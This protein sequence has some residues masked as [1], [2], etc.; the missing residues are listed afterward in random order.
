MHSGLF[1]FKNQSPIMENTPI[2][3]DEHPAD[4]EAEFLPAYRLNKYLA[5]CGIGS[6]RNC[7]QLITSGKVIVNGATCTNPA[8]Q[9]TTDDFV[10]YD[11]RRVLPKDTTTLLLHKP[12]HYVC[13]KSDENGRDTI[14]ELLPP[15]YQHLNH[16]GRLDLDSE[17]MLI[18]TNDGELANQLTHPRSKVDKEYVVTVNQSFD[19]EILDKFLNGIYLDGKPAR[20]KAVKRL[21][22]RRFLIV[23]NTGTKRQIRLMC[24]A[25]HLRVIKLV[26][27]RIGMLSLGD[28]PAGRF[29]LL[30]KDEI[31]F[32]TRNFDSLPKGYHDTPTEKHQ[33]KRPRKFKPRSTKR[34]SR[35]YRRR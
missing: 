28:I 29:R 33:D 19:N 8:T 34:S 2:P 18:V 30:E 15:T 31:H 3:P 12:R 10:K 9:V 27:I 35:S 24:K 32:L 14:Y 16:V 7:D 23:L 13:S 1:I 25:V 20:A 5:M 17:G 22:P 6:R 11:E 4:N 21:S 26:R